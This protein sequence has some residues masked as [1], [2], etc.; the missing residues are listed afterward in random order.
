MSSNGIATKAEI[1]AIAED[2]L[3][4]FDVDELRLPAAAIDQMVVPLAIEH[5]RNVYQCRINIPA[6]HAVH[7]ETEVD[8]L[9]KIETTARV[10][11]ARIKRDH[12]RALQIAKEAATQIGAGQ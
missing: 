12:P 3:D 11:L 2:G 6:N 8:R 9:T 10:A 4:L 1:E 7:N 5:I